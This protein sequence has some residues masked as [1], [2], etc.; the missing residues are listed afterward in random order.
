M[1]PQRLSRVVLSLVVVATAVSGVSVAPQPVIAAAPIS[2]PAPKMSTP[3]PIPPGPVS[4]GAAQA[5]PATVAPRSDLT[6]APVPTIPDTKGLSGQ[7]LLDAMAKSGDAQIRDVRHKNPKPGDDPRDAATV[8]IDTGAWLLFFTD[9]EDN[10]YQQGNPGTALDPF[11]QSGNVIVTGHVY[12]PEAVRLDAGATSTLGLFYLRA[13]G[14]LN[15]VMARTSTTDGA[16]WSA[17]TQL[18]SGAN[19]VYWIRSIVI[20]GTG[21]LFWSDTAGNLFYQTSADLSTWS[22]T[23]TVGH[24]VGPQTSYTSPSFDIAHLANGTW[25]LTYMERAVSCGAVGGCGTYD[26]PVV[27][28]VVGTSLSI[29]GDRPAARRSR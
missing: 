28:T 20:S 2:S 17:E 3:T 10:L 1:I 15:Q 25:L 16:S 4:Q 18:T 11:W 9:S 13:V 12:H 29:W 19:S 26:F 24:L 23:A 6:V 5:T 21:Y 27:Y 7:A 22:S 8:R 14:S